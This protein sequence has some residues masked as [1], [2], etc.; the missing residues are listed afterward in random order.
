MVK[1]TWWTAPTCPR[2]ADNDHPDS[3]DRAGDRAR[4]SGR[5]GGDGESTA[6][7]LVIYAPLDK[8]ARLAW[9]L[10]VTQDIFHSWIVMVDALNGG[11]LNKITQVQDANVAIS[12]KDLLGQTRN[13]NVWSQDN[14]FYMFDASKQ[15]F[16]AGTDPFKHETAAPAC[17]FDGADKTTDEV[18][19]SAAIISWQDGGAILADAVSAAFNFSL[20]YDYFQQHY[21]VIPSMARG[22]ASWQSCASL[23][24]NNAADRPR[25]RWCLATTS[26]RGG[27]RCTGHELTHGVTE[28]TAGLIYQDQSG[29][30]NEFGCPTSSAK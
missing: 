25:D 24:S 11:I 18:L 15:M 30:L 20:T 12:A 4:Q 9:K 28:K 14:K 23:T 5:R 10:S 16:V 27:P 8:P 29:A 1:F 21:P 22:E 7:I 17:I 6:P 13:L 26:P 2:P 19:N 3:D